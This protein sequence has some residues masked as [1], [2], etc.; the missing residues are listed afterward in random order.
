MPSCCD[1]CCAGSASHSWKSFVLA[2]EGVSRDDGTTDTRDYILIGAWPISQRVVDV[3]AATPRY[4]LRGEAAVS[5]TRIRR[6]S[7]RKPSSRDP[8]GKRSADVTE[9]DTY[10]SE[11]ADRFEEE[12]QELLRIPSVSTESRFAGD[13]QRCAEW[14]AADIER[15]GLERWRSFRPTATRWSTP[16]TG[17]MSSLRPC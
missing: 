4:L 6:A 5:A 3:W 11:N 14:V 10:L 12:L 17:R 9:I 16:S 1:L 8:S 13:V 15:A 7:R 2:V